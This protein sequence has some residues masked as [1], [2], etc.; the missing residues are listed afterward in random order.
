MSHLEYELVSSHVVESCGIWMS[1]VTYRL[2]MSDIKTN[3]YDV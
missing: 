3:L 1:L 2:V